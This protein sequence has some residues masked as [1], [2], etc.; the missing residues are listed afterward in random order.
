MTAR[1][2][3]TNKRGVISKNSS[4]LDKKKPEKKLTFKLKKRAGRSRKGRITVRHKGGGEKRKYREIDFKQSKIEVSAKVEAIEYDPCRSAFLML[5][6]YKDGDRKYR[7]APDKIKVGD[8]VICSE[9]ASVKVG[10]RMRIKN[11]PS[12]SMIFNVELIPDRGGKIVRSA[13]AVSHILSKDDGIANISLPSK[14]VRLVSEKCF[15][16]IGQVSNPDYRNKVIGKAGRMRHLG[17]RPTVRGTVM[18]PCDH[19]HGGGEGK[20]MIGMKHPKTPWG[21]PALG[22]RTRKKK[23]WSNRF[24]VKRRKK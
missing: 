10:N 9:K 14:E 19:P 3:K 21:N 18:N 5:L 8:E 2:K 1:I 17:K 13:G 24:I 11:I 16:T 12:G 6:L 20:S 22:K 7:L 4:C 15:A 23:K